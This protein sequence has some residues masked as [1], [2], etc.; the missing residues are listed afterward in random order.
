TGLTAAEAP[1]ILRGLVRGP[2][3]RT[4]HTDS[5]GGE[6]FQRKLAALPP[7][8]RDDLALD[9]VRTQAAV[10]LGHTSAATIEPDRAFRDLGFDSLSAVEL[11]NSLGAV[12]GK[13][14]PATLVFDHPNA[15][16]LT[17][18]LLSLLAPAANGTGEHEEAAV[19]SALRDLPLHRLRDAGLLDSL[20]E[21]AGIRTD[22]PDGAADEPEDDD[23]SIDT[24]DTED[25]INMAL[26]GSG[27]DD[28]MREA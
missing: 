26:D 12:V 19:R 3:R 28:L 13:R 16:A 11:R 17:D 10:A 1:E 25:L 27:L 20:L 6:A 15:R 24:M 5:G 2:A 23:V 7:A 8:D 4:A 14:L 18:H 9:T 21:L 22:R